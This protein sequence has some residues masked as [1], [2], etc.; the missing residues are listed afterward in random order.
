MNLRQLVRKSDTEWWIP[1]A[2]KMNVPGII[3]ATRELLHGMDDKVAEQVSNVAAL[4]GIV[5]GSFALPDAHWGY[6]FPIGGVGA[7]DPEAGSA[8]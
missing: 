3:F 4:P 1:R 5:R 8:R 2:G 6:G 7:F